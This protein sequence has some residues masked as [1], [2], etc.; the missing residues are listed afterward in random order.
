MFTLSLN[1]DKKQLLAEPQGKSGRIAEIDK[2]MAEYR[3]ERA[4]LVEK[5]KQTKPSRTSI[6]GGATGASADDMNKKLL[7]AVDESLNALAAEKAELLKEAAKTKAA[8]PT[9][10]EAKVVL[11]NGAIMY[12]VRI[13]K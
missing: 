11:P 13:R 9:G 3:Q 8:D 4:K 12:L 6:F 7:A 2:E 1:V 5:A 10:C